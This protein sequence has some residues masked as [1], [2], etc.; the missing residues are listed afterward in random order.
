MSNHHFVSYSV[1]DAREFALKLYIELIDEPLSV[2]A[3]IDKK[4]IKPG[5]D[6]DKQIVEAI[7]TCRSLIFVMTPDSVE[8]VSICKNEWTRALKYKKPIIPIL[9]HQDVEVPFQLGSRQYI[10]FT[11][12]FETALV[13]LKKHIRWLYS[14]EG[15]LQALKDRLADANRDLRRTEDSG[16]RTRITNETESL[17]Q[18][19]FELEQIVKDPEG[20]KERV[21]KSISTG[22]ERERQP[23]KP[24][25]GVT[26]TKFINPP[27][28]VAPTYWQNRHY[29]S[30]LIGKFLENE[31]ECLLTIVG[32]AGVG[33]TALACRLLKFLESGRL[34]RDVGRGQNPAGPPLQR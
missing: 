26:R 13:K 2:P 29:E 31:V 6:W 12:E 14:S 23:I 16:Q 20:A 28:G 4:E 32:R 10:D 8:D 5:Q 9:L 19:I 15:K 25:D 27:P 33:K 11:G 3:W 7:R 34:P 22:M 21:E 1:A 30:E 18:Q 17:K 24:T